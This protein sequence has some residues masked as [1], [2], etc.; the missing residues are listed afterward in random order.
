MFGITLLAVFFLGL[1]STA[2]AQVFSNDYH[3][4]NG[5]TYG[6]GGYGFENLPFGGFGFEYTQG[7][8]VSG[9]LMDRFGQVVGTTYVETGPIVEAVQPQIVQQPQAV[10]PA[11]RVAARFRI[12]KVPVQPRYTVT[13]GSLGWQGANGVVVNS[14]AMRYQSY[15]SGYALSPYGTTQYYGPW[16]GQTL[17]Y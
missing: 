16:K 12:K 6:P 13:T 5:Y 9:I 1:N 7:P 3:G 17:G 2:H 8:P 10:Q 11:G 15:G 4:L 14:P